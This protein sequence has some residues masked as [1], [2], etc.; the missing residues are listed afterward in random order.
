[1]LV[2]CF[3]QDCVLYLLNDWISI[4][5]SPKFISENNSIDSFFLNT[6]PY[7]PILVVCE[8]PAVNIE[9]K[10]KEIYRHCFKV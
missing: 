9:K 1:M 2:S 4:N 6:R 8:N 3:R 7:R 5:I 10:I